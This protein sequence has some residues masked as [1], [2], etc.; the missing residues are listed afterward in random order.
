[1]PVIT[2]SDDSS[3]MLY[4]SKFRTTLFTFRKDGSLPE[5]VVKIY[6]ISRKPE[7]DL[8][9]G[10][11]R[12]ILSCEEKL[13]RQSIPRLEFRQE[14]NGYYVVQEEFVD[15]RLMEKDA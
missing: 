15:G 11:F 5:K 8:M 4:N 2:Q 9:C 3:F 13:V 7:I 6:D 10:L 1:M 14:V 12:D